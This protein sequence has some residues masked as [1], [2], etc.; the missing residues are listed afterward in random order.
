[1]F[2]EAVVRESVRPNL[3]GLFADVAA[4]QD[5]VVR[6]AILFILLLLNFSHFL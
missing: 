5:D 1:V 6:V 3:V 4:A 2:N